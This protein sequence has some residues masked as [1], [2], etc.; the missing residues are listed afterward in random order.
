MKKS[1]SFFCRSVLFVMVCINCNAQSLKSSSN[2]VLSLNHL[3]SLS[4]M[5]KSEAGLGVEIISVIFPINPIIAVEDGKTYFGLTKEIGIGMVNAGH[6]SAEY[7]HLF[8]SENSNHLRFSYNYDFYPKPGD[9]AAFMISVG[10]GYFTDF[11]KKG[12]FPQA[13]LGM[14]LAFTDGVGI[15]PYIKLRNT[16][17]TD[18]TQADI[19]DFS[20]GLKTIFY[21]R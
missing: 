5:N 12:F 8:R 13:S 9:F 19:F 21:I 1:L 11:N 18:K 10:G 3:P 16:F 7:S 14:L 17:M 20:L 2:D 6:I 4:K 15:I